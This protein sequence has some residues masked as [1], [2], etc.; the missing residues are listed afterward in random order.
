[1]GADKKTVI[2]P[3]D[4]QQ[5]AIYQ[6]V[7]DA[8]TAAIASV[9]P[10]VT[11]RTPHNT[12]AK[13][14]T[15][16]LVDL[17]L[18]QGNPDSLYADGAYRRFFMHGTS[19]WLGLDVHDVGKYSDPDG[20]SRTLRPG[21][22]FTVEPGIYISP[23]DDIDRKWWYIGVRIEDDVLVTPKGQRVLSAD[24]PK[25]ILEIEAIMRPDRALNSQ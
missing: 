9:R 18:L 12:A 17:G 20:H 21:M 13:V 14:I 16:G 23:A 6:L 5:A 25:T 11:F 8:Q 4:E 3:D 10:G 22:V 15:R 2:L 19:H 24:I 1:M 7:L